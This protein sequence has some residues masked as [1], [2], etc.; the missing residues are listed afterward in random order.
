MLLHASYRFTNEASYLAL[1]LCILSSHGMISSVKELLDL[2]PAWK[3]YQ[4]QHN[5]QMS[6]PAMAQLLLNTFYYK[7]FFAYYAFMFWGSLMVKGDKLEIF[8]LNAEGTRC[9]CMELRKD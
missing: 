3:I 4:H 7:R 1:A 9:E 6:T 8:V 2:A 5:K